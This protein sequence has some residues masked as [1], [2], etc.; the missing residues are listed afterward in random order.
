MSKPARL[1][2]PHRIKT[3]NCKRSGVK[4]SSTPIGRRGETRGVAIA[5]TVP[6]A[7]PG[8]SQGA[9][10]MPSFVSLNR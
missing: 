4:A 10:C 3:G 1:Y 9:E 2:Y 8:I 6:V 5:C 7:S